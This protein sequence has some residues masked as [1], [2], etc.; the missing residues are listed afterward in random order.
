[1]SHTHSH[2]HG[3]PCDHAAAHAP[4]A[5][6]QRAMIV[7]LCLSA[8]YMIA[9]AVGGFWT[10]SLALLADAGHMLS[11]VAALALGVFAGW[12]ARRPASAARTYGYY[13]A[14]ILAALVNSAMLIAIAVLIVI[15]AV[16]RAF[17]PE[18]VHGLPMLFIAAGGLA[19][20]LVSLWIL[21]SGKEHSL[22]VH[23]AWLHVFADAL[24]SLGAVLSGALIWRFGWFWADSLTSIVIAA[25][26]TWSSWS[27]LRR[28]LSVLMEGTPHGLSLDELS[29]SMLALPS[30][31][32]VHD[33][34]VWS[35]TTGMDALSA[36]VVVENGA[37]GDAVLQSIAATLKERF[38][39]A[40]STVQI[41][42]L[43]CEAPVH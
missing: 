14:E 41:E 6:G 18:P 12:I 11:D 22:N 2:V 40:H 37:D 9:E 29:R 27:L 15:E 26:V 20:N 36:H 42:R 7:V 5:Q 3:D 19:V 31:V 33:L 43:R 4:R 10:H 13:R 24:G 34:H 1:M 21:R 32:E 35:I 39:I 8:T 38:G 30:V 23:G 28:A 25:L 17:H 16:G